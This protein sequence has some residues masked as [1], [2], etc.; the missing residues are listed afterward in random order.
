LHGVSAGL[1]FD[2]SQRLGVGN[3]FPA[4]G[5]L[6]R[7]ETDKTRQVMELAGPVGGL[8]EKGMDAWGAAQTRKD[9]AHKT[10]AMLKAGMPKAFADAWQALDMLNTGQYSDARG[11]KVADTNGVD[12]MSKF[13]GFQPTDVAEKRREDRFKNQAVQL[14]KAVEGDIASLWA[15]GMNEKKPDKVQEAK[16][17]LK[18]W[19]LKNPETPIR[20]SH[21]QIVRRVKQMKMTAHERLLKSM[22][23]ELRNFV[24]G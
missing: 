15:A 4:T 13:L 5:L 1:P 14:T 18:D 19:N 8:L 20:I 9:A 24:G 6:K 11:R 16:D 22:P 23:K 10:A 2:V 3:V 7:S 17:L 12:A 21:S